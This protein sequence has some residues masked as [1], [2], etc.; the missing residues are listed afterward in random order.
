MPSSFAKRRVAFATALVIT[1]CVWLA[2]STS[3]FPALSDDHPQNLH[4]IESDDPVVVREGEW[5]TQAAAGASG[6]SYL[7]NTAVNPDRPDPALTL[8][9]SGTDL[10]VIYVS[11]PNLGTLAIEVDGTVLRTVIAASD[12][13]QYNLHTSINYLTDELHTLRVYAQSGGVVGVDAFVVN[14]NP[15]MSTISPI[16]GDITSVGG[17]GTRVLD[18]VSRDAIQ[19]LSSPYN[20]TGGGNT[21]SYYPDMSTDGRYVVFVT[22]SNSNL[23]P[24]DNN[25]V[26]DI[27]LVDRQSCTAT[28]VS[29]NNAGNLI[30]HNAWYPAISDDGRYVVFA[31]EANNLGPST[32]PVYQKVYLRDRQTNQTTLV[33]RSSSGGVSGGNYPHI[34]G[35]G[36][37]VAFSS[38]ANDLV[39]GD[40]NGLWDVF[41]RDLQTNTTVRVSVR[42]DGTQ[43]TAGSI[44]G[45]PWI[46][47]DGRYVTFSA[48]G[49]NLTG[50][51]VS[52]IQVY[53]YDLQTGQLRLLS[54]NSQGISGNNHSED[55]RISGNGQ[56]V[57]FSSYATNL[58]LGDTDTLSD[59]YLY[60]ITNN[61]L[62]LLTRGYGN[63]PS[64]GSSYEASISTDGVFV[65]FYSRA[66]N[67]LPYPVSDDTVYRLDRFTGD[68]IPI[69]VRYDAS[70]LV[71]SGTS[72]ETSPISSS[73]RLIVY[74]S[75]STNVLASETLGWQ[76]Y[77]RDLDAL[78]PPSQLTGVVNSPS[79]ITLNWTLYDATATE[80]HVERSPVNTSSFTEVGIVS[81]N[82]TSFTDT[83]L[84]S[85]T[86]YYYRVRAYRSSDTR[87]SSYSNVANYRTHTRNIP[88][89]NVSVTGRTSIE[90][91]WTDTNP[92]E[93]EYHLER[94]LPSSGDFEEIAV[95][96][97]TSSTYTYTDTNLAIF[98]GYSYRIRAYW[99]SDGQFSNYSSVYSATTYPACAPNA[100]V[101]RVAMDNNGK[102]VIARDAD[103]NGNGR[104]II[105]S[106][107]DPVQP[108]DTANYFLQV[109][110]HDTLTCNTTLI[111]RTNDGQRANDDAEVGSISDD[112]RWVAFASE[113]INL[114]SNTSARIYQ[115]YLHDLQS[116]QTILVSHTPNGMPGDAR[117]LSPEISSDGRFIT[118]YSDATNLV[119][120]DAVPAVSDIYV[121]DRQTDQISRVSVDS[122]GNAGNGNSSYP[123]ISDDGR[124]VAF[125]SL[126][127]NLVA[128]DTN[129]RRD[130][131]VHDRQL[132]QTI[133]ISTRMDGTQT[134]ADSWSPMISGNGHY[135]VF[136]AHDA[137]SSDPLE[138]PGQIYL[139]DL[140]TG[141]L[142]LISRTADGAFADRLC[143]YP[144]ITPDGRYV[145]YATLATNLGDDSPDTMINAI[146]NYVYDRQ[147]QTNF[148]AN[149][150]YLGNVAIVGSGGG[151]NAISDDGLI[152]LWR[153]T[154]GY[155]LPYS[156]GSG[157][158]IYNRN[159]SPSPTPTNTPTSTHTFT[160]TASATAS[161][162][163]SSTP[164]NTATWT[165]TP[166]ATPSQTA[167]NTPSAT[168]TSSATVTPSATHTPT[169]TATWTFTPTAT[170][171]STNTPTS[172][173]TSTPSVQP[174]AT[175]TATPTFTRTPSPTP[176]ATGTPSPTA[177]ATHTPQNFDT[178]AIYDTQN[179]R[180]YLVNTLDSQSNQL[181]TVQL[182]SPNPI[183]GVMG[184]WN[185]DGLKTPGYYAGGVFYTT[186]LLNPT[187]PSDWTATWFGLMGRP[188]LAGHFAGSSHDCIG[189][190]DSG[191]F[192]PY[193]IAFALYYT[194]DFS[195]P[196]PDKSFQWLSVVL[197][198][199]QGFTG[200]HQFE[201]GDFDGD[202]SDSV[203]IRRGKFIAYTNITPGAGHAAFAYAQY[204]GT[205]DSSGEGDF[206]TGDWDGNGRDSFGVYY[207]TSH[208]FYRRNDLDWNS[209][210]YLTQSLP[211]LNATAV[212]VSSWRVR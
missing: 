81:A 4:T 121:Y 184:D 20:G 181:Q 87:L 212:S 45:R 167:S 38:G 196:N 56:F 73:G 127:T 144:V 173:P 41:V 75:N 105:F 77:L 135:I 151:R 66:R 86:M 21:H 99:A 29:V 186:N 138:P 60:D 204:W 192:P 62:S 26:S 114:V 193:G 119:A 47:D 107:A 5:T 161:Q 208:L 128:N 206:V 197:P 140:Q 165:G 130:I 40:T 34:S 48:M 178:L 89:V 126:A 97:A 35:N 103:M 88:Y 179:Q 7:Y 190:V 78:F 123:S 188:A 164:S 148:N 134:S 15:I 25:G 104:Y 150:D 53:L 166:T 162:T 152:T 142:E 71:V 1:V 24:N 187:R 17:I 74:V 106:S 194:C 111:S 100:L 59:I 137:L 52:W 158:Y 198:D 92:S 143:E 118:F 210:V 189:V 133:R 200:T 159:Y 32:Y 18:C 22:D 85:N 13:T 201:T 191:Y 147:T 175:Y 156:G 163:P 23:F 51:A 205:P 43:M 95:L 8:Q 209:G 129:A 125:E 54:R 37:F 124:Y 31:S 145:F 44:Q 168:P 203:A 61:T 109:Y 55:P 2:L 82:T 101:Q 69:G 136:A 84:A 11:G 141:M 202:G 27:V 174:S 185:G 72:S 36:R 153:A 64:S 112:G 207:P 146:D 211:M 131:F 70:R 63:T 102:P 182:S 50:T 139:R 46:S 116:G 80:F 90:L 117:S 39:Q 76:V 157:Y 149:R 122:N 42:S 120:G 170:A 83:G 183:V 199:E 30:D 6:G 180:L 115:I 67:L 68:L 108:M 155:V 176:S 113:A 91:S 14:S 177:S 9:F 79:T 3:L 96:P 65:T 93:T 132:S 169:L 160:P 171:S 57:V 98:T 10:E 49:A 110:V 195:Q 58:G 172:T 94:Q 154:G 28:P 16:K 19:I 33:S 12:R